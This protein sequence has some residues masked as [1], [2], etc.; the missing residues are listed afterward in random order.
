M[1]CIFCKIANGEIP[2][3]KVYEDAA[4]VA[5]LDISPRNPGH[6]IVIPKKHYG[7]IL[8][9]PESELASVMSTV[10]KAVIATKNATNS[11]GTNIVQNNGRAAG[12][13]V[14][15][16]HF[17]VIPRFMSE[18]PPSLEGILQVKRFDRENR[19]NPHACNPRP[20]DDPSRD[21]PDIAASRAL[22]RSWLRQPGRR[23]RLQ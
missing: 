5:F 20:S 9:V 8:D 12:Q 3:N 22:E 2:A 16:I 11:E 13:V 21:A 1:D 18:G 17:H 6:T 4:T 10:K 7:S 15:H 19:R 14:A 23:L